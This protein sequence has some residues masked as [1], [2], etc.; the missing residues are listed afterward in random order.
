[1]SSDG[2]G[3]VVEALLFLSPEPVSAAELAEAIEVDEEAV[4]E[5]IEGLAGSLA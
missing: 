2:L 4:A 5:A 1:M 3:T